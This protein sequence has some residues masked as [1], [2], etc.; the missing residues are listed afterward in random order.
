MEELHS[1]TVLGTQFKVP[2]KYEPLKA[3]G[4]GAYGIVCAARNVETGQKVA[5]K[6]VTPMAANSTDGKHTLRECKLMRWLGKHPNIISLRDIH[7]NPAEDELYFIMDLFDTDLH[8]IIQSPQPLGDAH[9]KHFLYQLLR[10]LKFAHDNGVLHRDLKPANLLVTKN[11]DLC[12][13]DFGLA[14]QMPGVDQSPIMTEHVVTR[15]YRAPELMLSADGH[16]TP[17]IDVWSVGCILAELLGRT[18]LFAGKDFMETLRMQ[19]DILGTRPKEEIAF[20]R[21]QQALD[22]LDALPYRQPTPWKTLFPDASDRVLDLLD[23]MLQFAAPKR[24][25]VEDALAH[26]YFDSVRSQYQFE[27]PVLPTGTNGFDFTFET[28]RSLSASDYRRLILEEASSF[29]NEKAMERRM[30]MER[31]ADRAAEKSA[32]KKGSES[33]QLPPGGSA[34]AQDADAVHSSKGTV[35]YNRST[36]EAHRK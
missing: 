16:Y 8:K 24:I 15:W 19:I 7:C 23:K 31:A 30:R 4:K 33:K 21:S 10:G 11:C 22:F 26:P 34:S 1:F 28:S 9:L 20:I 25:S 2:K 36:V 29:K 3:L 6:K 32:Q 17:A 18:P 12:I 13:S 27:D 5:V 14:R 35:A